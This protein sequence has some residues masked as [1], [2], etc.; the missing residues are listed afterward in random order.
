MSSGWSTAAASIAPS[1]IPVATRTD[2]VR[3]SQ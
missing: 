3:G 2:R 1:A